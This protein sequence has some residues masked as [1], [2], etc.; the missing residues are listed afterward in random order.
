MGMVTWKQRLW[1]ACSVLL[2]VASTQ[3]VI[4]TFEDAAEK[5]PTKAHGAGGQ[6]DQCHLTNSR[7][8]QN[9]E[10]VPVGN[11]SYDFKCWI[12]KTR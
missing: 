3:A 9:G 8:E 1:K 12:L 4:W 2:L 10:F 5:T 6:D 7:M 11:S